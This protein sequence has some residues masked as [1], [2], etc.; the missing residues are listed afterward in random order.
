MVDQ[1]VSWFPAGGAAGM[2]HIVGEK[3]VDPQEWFFSAHFYQDPVIPGSLGLEAF[4]QLL[5]VVAQKKWGEDVL[6]T[7]EVE[8]IAMDRLHRWWYRGQ[9][10]PSHSRVRVEASLTEIREDERERL[11]GADGFVSVDGR[12]IYELRDFALRLRRS[13]T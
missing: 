5:K 13:L 11:L 7:W 10:I 12:I 1:I 9:V 2:G 3:A 4:L 6:T 8:P